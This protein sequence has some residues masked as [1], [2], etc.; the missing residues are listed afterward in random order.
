MSSKFYLKFFTAISSFLGLFTI[1]CFTFSLPVKAALPCKGGTINTY[2]NGSIES[3]IIDNHVDVKA[4]SL[5]FS[6]KQ[7]YSISFDDKANFQSCVLFKPVTIRR[8]NAVETCSENSR[9]YVS[10]SKQGNQSVICHY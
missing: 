4:G 9:V 2:Q 1:N 3:C 8:N 7:G 10:F 6:C 5:A